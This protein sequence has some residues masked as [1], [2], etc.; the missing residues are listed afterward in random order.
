MAGNN[1]NTLR[2]M[3]NP[4]LMSLDVLA[5]NANPL[6]N[7]VH[8]GDFTPCAVNRVPAT[9]MAMAAEGKGVNVA[10]FLARH[11]HRVA[12]AGF[13]GGHSGAWLREMVRTEG[14]VDACVETEA[15]LRVGFMA[16]GGCGTQHPTTVLPSG[17]PV[18]LAECKALL[19]KIDSLLDSVRLVI[20]SGSVP[21]PVADGFYVDLLALCA[22]RGVP[23]WLDAYGPAMGLALAG[24]VPPP[25]AKPNR[26]ELASGRH[27]DRV[28]ELHITDGANPVEVGSQQEGRWRVTPPAIRQVNPIGSGDCYLA[29]LAH[30][31]LSGWGFADRLRYAAS[32]GSANA[33]KL[34]VAT[35]SPAE[36]EALLSQVRVERQ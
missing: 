5:V 1:N 6:L 16:Q 33:L 24:P 7:L 34:E 22:R 15:P 14:V 8:S 21:A 35:I 12:L 28:G 23:C 11:G 19:L 2:L 36:V 13:A 17:F 31:W 25:L 10:R 20:A 3:E 27:W 4:P 26:E 32:A 30:G 29:A 9:G 18:T